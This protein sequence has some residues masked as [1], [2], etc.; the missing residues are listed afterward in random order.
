MGLQL[1]TLLQELKFL[2]VNCAFLGAYFIP[3]GV[4]GSLVAAWKGYVGRSVGFGIV[5]LVLLD[6]LIPLPRRPHFNKTYCYLTGIEDGMKTYCKGEL[7]MKT[8]FRK[9]RNYLV[10]LAPHGLWT[11]CYHLLWP[12]MVQRFGIT[13]LVIGADVLLKIP[14]FKRH[15]HAYGVIGASR[16][17]LQW[18]LKQ[19][20]PFNVTVIVTG[21]IAE[22]FYGISR[23]QIILK[24]RKGFV[25]YALQTGSDLVPAYGFG[26]NQ[27]YRRFIEA[28]SALAKFSS[29]LQVS[30]A[31]WADRFCIPFGFVPR[32]HKVIMAVGEPIPVE[33]V[34]SPTDE[35]VEA[36]HVKFC[37]AM[38]ALF[39]EHKSAMGWE[40]RKLY[41]EDEKP[42][43][44]S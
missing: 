20:Y 16:K 43:K 44:Q 38:K 29:M 11:M 34:E 17:D 37:L 6:A 39:D 24:K 22:M 33:K 31:P 42:Q 8:E 36:L 4:V 28:G 19:Q 3:F 32:K 10:A 41:L 27:Q 12:T 35:Q 5:G 7:R 23:E 2:A 13:P 1:S 26:T 15:F 40:D 18:A 25:K 9:D 21:G 14:F 30:I